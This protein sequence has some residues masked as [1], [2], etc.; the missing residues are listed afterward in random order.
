MKQLALA[1]CL[2]LVACAANPADLPRDGEPGPVEAGTAPL[3]EDLGTFHRAVQ[4][5]SPEAQRYFDQGLI[6]AY[7]F[8]HDEAIRAFEEAARLD[9]TCAMAWWGIA[10]ARG[11]HLNNTAVDPA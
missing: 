10:Y 4:T 3:W 2:T 5:T 9:P 8:N 6:L 7:G 1:L 11:P